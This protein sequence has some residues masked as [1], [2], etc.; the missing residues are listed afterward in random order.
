MLGLETKEKVLQI[1]LKAV[2]SFQ[3]RYQGKEDNA[4]T[5]VT[6]A[7]LWRRR[8]IEATYRQAEENLRC[9]SY[10]WYRD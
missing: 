2:E 3:G 1:C 9:S 8:R 7:K 10:T 5:M 6:M 4:V